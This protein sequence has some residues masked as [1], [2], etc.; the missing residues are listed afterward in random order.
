MSEDFV[1]YPQTA[2]RSNNDSTENRIIGPKLKV[3][4]IVDPILN[5]LSPK[6]LNSSSADNNAIF[7]I[8]SKIIKK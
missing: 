5:V 6:L 3:V 2:K 1:R 8:D 4:E 7:L